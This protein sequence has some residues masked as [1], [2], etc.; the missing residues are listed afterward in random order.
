[1]DR[2]LNRNTN[3]GPLADELAEELGIGVDTLS[4]I[5]H[6]LANLSVFSAA[7]QKSWAPINI[8]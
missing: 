1:M 4:G 7:V 6:H 2:D 8:T 5:V 3:I